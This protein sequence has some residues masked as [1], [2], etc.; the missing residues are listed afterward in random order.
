MTAAGRTSALYTLCFC[1]IA[2]TDDTLIHTHALTDIEHAYTPSWW[3]ACPSWSCVH[4]SRPWSAPTSWLPR[5]PP[6][7]YSPH[8]MRDKRGGREEDR[9]SQYRGGI[10]KSVV[11]GQGISSDDWREQGQIWR[12][13]KEKWMGERRGLGGIALFQIHISSCWE[14]SQIYFHLQSIWYEM[15]SISPL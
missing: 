11:F 3:V 1:F 6:E 12:W 4:V 13:Q 9:V 8:P 7:P 5:Q 10:G 2:A 14:A 15:P